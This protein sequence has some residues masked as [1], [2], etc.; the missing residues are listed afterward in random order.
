MKEMLDIVKWY[1]EVKETLYK[2]EHLYGVYLP[3]EYHT[4]AY[5]ELL[6]MY[7]NAYK[8][9]KRLCYS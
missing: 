6:N 2:V 8:E 4:D 1:I 9:L 7:H 5:N 3:I